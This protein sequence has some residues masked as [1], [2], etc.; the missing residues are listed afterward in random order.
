MIDWNWLGSFLS[1]KQS[2]NSSL[3]SSK[4]GEWLKLYAFKILRRVSKTKTL[5]SS[6]L[7]QRKVKWVIGSALVAQCSSLWGVSSLFCAILHLLETRYF[8]FKPNDV[9]AIADKDFIKSET[10]LLCSPPCCQSN[11][12]SDL[13]MSPHVS[14]TTPWPLCQGWGA[15]C[16]FSIFLF[17]DQGLL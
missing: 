3:Y 14:I 2:R 11:L 6:K 9:L 4:L 16:F 13:A 5:Y 1:W 7:M 10:V 8:S 12:T 17:K 15:P